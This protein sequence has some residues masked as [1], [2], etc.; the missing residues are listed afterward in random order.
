[1]PNWH[2]SL[3]AEESASSFFTTGFTS[4]WSAAWFVLVDGA[5][6]LEVGGLSIDGDEDG[7][8]VASPCS[9]EYSMEAGGGCDSLDS[10][11]SSFARLALGSSSFVVLSIV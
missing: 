1:M 8:G 5:S 6:G 3:N 2:D 10:S 4:G 11:F 7:A 9:C